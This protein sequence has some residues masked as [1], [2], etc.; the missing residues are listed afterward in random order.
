MLY[1]LSY[2]GALVRLAKGRPP[3]EVGALYEDRPG[4]SSRFLH[5]R[6]WWTWEW[7]GGIGSGCGKANGDGCPA[8]RRDGTVFVGGT[9]FQCCSEKLERWMSRPGAAGARRAEKTDWR[10]LVIRRPWIGCQPTICGPP[11][12]TAKAAV[13]N[14]C[15]GLR[16]FSTAS[17]RAID[18]LPRRRLRFAQGYVRRP[19][20]SATCC[21]SSVVEHSIGNGEVGSSILPRS[22]SFPVKALHV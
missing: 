19:S 10:G 3:R 4:L 11:V 22:T 21:G 5:Y 7:S 20:L 15:L 18:A 1:Q 9:I 17:V 8:R 14:E 16:G 13:R 6:K 12:A 2:L